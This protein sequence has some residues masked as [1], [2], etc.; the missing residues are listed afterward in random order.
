MAVAGSAAAVAEEAPSGGYRFELIHVDA[1]GNF[2]REELIRRAAN[3]ARLRAAMLSAEDEDDTNSPAVS[4]SSSVPVEYSP[5]A[6][7][8]ELK[9]GS[10]APGTTLKAVA[11]TGSDLIWTNQLQ[12]CIDS[13]SFT[14]TNTLYSKKYGGGAMIGFMGMETVALPPGTGTGGKKEEEVKLA[15]AI[16]W[17]EKMLPEAGQ[18]IVGLS[19]GAMSLVSQLGVTKFSYCLT[20]PLQPALRSPLLLGG[21]VQSAAGGKD[22]WRTTDLVEI[23]TELS[24]QPERAKND[25]YVAL[26]KICIQGKCS[27]PLKQEHFRLKSSQ[28]KGLMLVDSG[29]TYTHL[30]TGIFE[31]LKKQLKEVLKVPV[32]KTEDGMNCFEKREPDVVRGFE[33]KPHLVLR[34]AGADLSLPWDTYVEEVEQRFCLTM[35]GGGMS[36]LGNVQQNTVSMLYDLAQKK[37]SFKRVDDC[38]RLL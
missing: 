14:P 10:T 32:E 1:N 33:P 24:G 18:G 21:D 38:T 27:E 30:D 34:F 28:G 5:K 3:R 23:S 25:Y 12:A 16:V 15:C 22:G 17:S 36:I 2:S 19:R 11:D 20:D 37:L 31:A 13:P 4:G 8:M 7:L 26:D 6:Y 35:L 29:T 9:M